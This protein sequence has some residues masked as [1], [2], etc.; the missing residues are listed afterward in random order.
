LLRLISLPVS[1]LILTPEQTIYISQKLIPRIEKDIKI[2]KEELYRIL[3]SGARKITEE[4]SALREKISREDIYILN[5]EEES[6]ENV[7]GYVKELYENLRKTV[8]KSISDSL[9]SSDLKDWEKKVLI[10]G[11]IYDR[12][13]VVELLQDKEG[14]SISQIINDLKEIEDSESSLGD[15]RDIPRIDMNRYRCR[16]TRFEYSLELSRNG[17]LDLYNR[18]GSF[19][20]FYRQVKSE[21]EQYSHHIKEVSS[22]LK[23]LSV[24]E[25][26]KSMLASV[27]LTLEKRLQLEKLKNILKRRAA[28]ISHVIEPLLIEQNK[29]A[30]EEADALFAGRAI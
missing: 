10:D 2:P 13:K 22:F 26:E 6:E 17:T 1:D 12:K 25:E 24:P 19:Q 9:P 20:C 23:A 30:R 7:E 27:I 16:D 4:L 15:T 28:R 11:Y 3:D 18:W 14:M 5:C 29:E 21:I 8:R